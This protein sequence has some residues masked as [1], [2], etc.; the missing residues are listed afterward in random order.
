MVPIDVYKAFWNH[1]AD[2]TGIDQVL[3]VSDE[4]ELQNLIKEVE[5][6][7]TILIAIIPSSDSHA[8]DDDNIEEM[9]PCV[10][11]VVKKID[12]AA[13]SYDEMLAVRGLTQGLITSVKLQMKIHKLDVNEN[14]PGTILMRRLDLNKLHTEP[15]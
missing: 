11:F 3:I 8:L 10:I 12:P 13:Y 1:L 6:Q 14:D 15:E 4:P 9:D 5:D 2:L 7:S